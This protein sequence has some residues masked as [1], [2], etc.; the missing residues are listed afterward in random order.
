MRTRSE[1]ARRPFTL[2]AIASIVILLSVEASA[3]PDPMNIP[4]PPDACRND[5]FGGL[6]TSHGNVEAI[7]LLLGTDLCAVRKLNR[8]RLE[9]DLA[10]VHASE[11]TGRIL[12]SLEI[13]GFL[14]RQFAKGWRAVFR[15]TGQ[16]D[17]RAGLDS[18]FLAGPGIGI[19]RFRALSSISLDSGVVWIV[20]S[21]QGRSTEQFPELWI[22]LESHRNLGKTAVYH[23]KLDGSGNLNQVGEYRL[24]WENDV[25]LHL[26]KKLSLKVG[27]DLNWDTRP[28]QHFKEFDASTHTLF[29]YSPGRTA[30]AAPR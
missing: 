27:A 19:D 14:D 28:A 15:A 1:T 10:V 29:V 25:L 8:A 22:K 6:N 16:A 18:R 21:K 20:E 2:L 12:E 23:Q 7:A 3:Q 9:A 11:G 5:V 13:E 24:S 26:T 17:D 30:G 4:D